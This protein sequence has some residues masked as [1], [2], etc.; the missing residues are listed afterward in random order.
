MRRVTV[1][2]SGRV[3]GVG[4][5]Y[6]TRK[7]ALELSLA[8]YAENLPDGRVEVVAEGEEA[9]LEL[10]LHHLRQGPREARV[11]H[12]EVQWSEATGLRGFQ[13]Y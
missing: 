2:V 5:R 8:G 13:I 10:F 12:L 4:Y 1:L 11:E 9:D 3:Q 7:K 6:F